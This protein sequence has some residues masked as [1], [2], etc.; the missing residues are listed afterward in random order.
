[1]VLTWD[2]F[3][4]LATVITNLQKS[5]VF[6]FN[7]KRTGIEE[8]NRGVAAAAKEYLEFLSNFKYLQFMEDL[9]ISLT[10]ILLFSYLKITMIEG[11]KI[12]FNF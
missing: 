2:E 12:I 7:N 4:K 6:I 5:I 1:M 11:R 10:K 8:K 9:R 3:L